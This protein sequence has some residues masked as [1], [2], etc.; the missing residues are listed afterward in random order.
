MALSS[1]ST[2]LTSIRQAGCTSLAL[3]QAAFASMS[4]CE[5]PNHFIVG[6]VGNRECHL[7]FLNAAGV[8]NCTAIILF[9]AT[10]WPAMLCRKF[11]RHVKPALAIESDSLRNRSVR[12]IKLQV[13][14]VFSYLR[15]DMLS[16]PHSGRHFVVRS[17]RSCFRIS[18]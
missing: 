16:A 17:H 5:G 14:A 11:S 1:E 7:L 8:A 4:K 12:A 18:D 9:I 10:N 3:H 15:V 13:G 6:R 2:R